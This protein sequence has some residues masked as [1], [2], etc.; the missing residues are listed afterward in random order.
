[1]IPTCPG[2]NFTG[3]PPHR[4]NKTLVFKLLTHKLGGI[5]SAAWLLYNSNCR[6]TKPV[7][8][9][10]VCSSDQRVHC[11]D[12]R[13]DVVFD[14]LYWFGLCELEIIILYYLKGVLYLCRGCAARRAVQDQVIW[15]CWMKDEACSPSG[16]SMW[17]SSG[18]RH[19]AAVLERPRTQNN[20]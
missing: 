6:D 12:Q 7:V 1:M 18:P 10:V 17:F 8:W 11:W 13:P 16:V 3:T 9:G 15:A 20:M 4:A 14:H 5:P 2:Y 19:W